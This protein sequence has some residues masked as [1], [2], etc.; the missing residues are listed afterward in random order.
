MKG[1]LKKNILVNLVGFFTARAV[2]MGINPLGIG[3]LAAAYMEKAGG[4]LIF[5]VIFIGIATTMAPIMVLKYLLAMITTAIIMEAPAF[6]RNRI[7]Q[8]VLHVL[9]AL[10]LSVF[11]LI[12]AFS[13]GV[14]IN[15]VALAI[16]E[17]VI[18]YTS[19]IIFRSGINFFMQGNK[20]LRL[21]NEQTVSLAVIIAIIIYSLPEYHNMYIAPVETLIYFLI[22][23]FTYK[24][25]IGQGTVAG[26]VSGFALCLRGVDLSYI[27]VLTIMG[28]I[29]AVLRDLGRFAT[30]AAFAATAVLI[31][32][33]YKDMALD[34]DQA[35]ALASAILIFIFLPQS[36]VYRVDVAADEG[37]RENA[38]TNLKRVANARMKIFSDSFIKLSR[39]LESITEKQTKLRQQELNGIFED[40]SERLC[41]NCRN[42]NLCWENNFDQ[43]YSAA[44]KMFDIAE[45]NGFVAK[46]DIPRQF[47]ESCICFEQFIMETNKGFEIAK[48]NHIWNRRIAE[49]REVI[50]QQL[51][52]VSSVIQNITGDFYEVMQNVRQQ[53]GRIVKRLREG[54][55]R[56]KNITIIERTDKKKE[57]YLSAATTKDRCITAKEAAVLIS[58]AIGV[59]LKVSE[60]SKTVISKE[61][62]NY[63]FVEDTKF[64]VLTGIARAMKDNVSGDNFSVLHLESGET[65]IALADGMGTGKE[66]GDESETVISLLE[67]MIEA[68]FKTETA[69]RLI[70]SSLVLKSDRHSFSTIDLS[71]INLFT[72]MCEFIKIGAATAF[73]KR[74]DWV[75]TISS[76]TLPIGMLGSV[77]YDSVSKK[78]YDGDIVIMVTDG[79]LDCLKEEDKEDTMEK[80]ILDIKSNNPQE[81][82]NRIL[83]N[84]LS[85][86]DN[87]PVDDMTVITAG[88]WH[89]Q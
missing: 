35:G 64:K 12:E 31:G 5:T 19:S 2:F 63:I 9:P 78:L 70:N 89:R 39:T 81:I 24:Y 25:G 48:L 23:L 52:E 62:D 43:T 16:L 74:E 4:G 85:Q 18:A 17:G 15:H 10:S 50:A 54:H 49:S 82:A 57:I 55:I 30:A 33:F 13:G 75:E 22:L 51:R 60:A 14:N 84:A 7:P 76:T 27:G 34:V 87:V 37:G 61:F 40:I 8:P 32:V 86:N 11:S 56:A 80:I 65:M 3:F 59:R 36:L 42:C 67:Q 66:A 71:I 83:D 73:I 46:E 47:L 88:L 69:I 53:E 28:I 1:K 79:V 77:D 26:A 29:P 44:C 41:K 21:S 72:G 58:E 20:G 6:I 38:L 45:K 68:G